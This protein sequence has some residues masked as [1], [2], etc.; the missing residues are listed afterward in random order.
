MHAWFFV[1]KVFSFFAF[2]TRNRWSWQ[3]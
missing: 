3:F 2:R 1:A